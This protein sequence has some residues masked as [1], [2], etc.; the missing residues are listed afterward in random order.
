MALAEAIPKAVVLGDRMQ[1][2]FTFVG[3]MATWSDHMLPKF[4]QPWSDLNLT[5]GPT[6][7]VS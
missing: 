3:P 5:A 7:I 2:I 6:T 1:A 4:P